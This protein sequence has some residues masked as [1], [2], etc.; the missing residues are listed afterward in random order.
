M[1]TETKKNGSA[2]NFSPNGS[3]HFDQT[4]VL[5]GQNEIKGRECELL[6]SLNND[7]A[8]ARNNDE[9]LD[10]I[11]QNL[12]NLLGFSHTLIC[13]IN[14]D[15]NTVSAFLLDPEAKAKNHPVYQ[16][17]KKGKYPI[18]DGVMDKS[19][20][21]PLP[22]IFDLEI[23]KIDQELPLYLQINYEMGIRQ[24]VVTRFSKREEVFGFWMV[25][26]DEKKDFDRS[27]LKLVNCLA[28][29]ISVAVS[30][31]IANEEI[32]SRESEKSGILA[33]SNAIASERDSRVLANVLKQQLKKLFNIEDY[34]I[35]ALSDD[36]T[37]L[38]PVLFDQLADFNKYPDFLKSLTFQGGAIRELVYDILTSKVPVIF[39]FS[40]WFFSDGVPANF[41]ST[42][43]AAGKRMIGTPLR[44]G[45][46]NIAV[47]IF[48]K[49]DVSELKAQDHLFKSI[50]SQIAIT[51][52]NLIANEKLTGQL[53]EI[54]SYKQQ[55][56]QERTYLKEEIE[57]G[58]NYSEIVGNSSEMQKIFRLVEQVAHSD[59]TV[60]L[61]GETGTGKELIARAIHNA[62]PRKSQL[63][64]K[65][66][67]AALPSNLI[68]SELFGHERGSFT[69]ATERRIGKFE[70][71]NNGTLFLDEV[72]EM[73]LDLQAKL[74]R[75]LQEREIERV[76]G[77]TTIKV[78]VR[79][80]AATNRDL[81]KEMDEGRFRSDLF[82]RL[83]IFPI[84]LPPL[85]QRK[86]DIPLLADFFIQ[87]FSKKAG[88]KIN[89]LS[90]HALQELISYHWPGNIR[91]LEHLIERS[92]LLT[93]GDTI[94]Q[95]YLPAQKQNLAEASTSDVFVVKSLDE[96]ER[97]HIL[98]MLKHCKGRISGS[99]GAA[100]LLGVPPS[101]LNSKTKKLG[102][103]REHLA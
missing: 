15:R 50:C 89:S 39:N 83:N 67:C 88:K 93:P 95:I 63:M 76:G 90:N 16:T 87:R 80:I 26:F 85:R 84:C 25:F 27:K 2:L 24:V 31:I 29:Q 66:N 35:Y 19:H 99:G 79:I 43:I 30:N 53:G 7:I 11:T 37:A 23:L 46:E 58:Q 75:A 65:V 13:T 59:S 60:L 94:K 36:K 12:K 56:E 102:I 32:A 86:E 21:T 40:E 52:A 61:L 96:N 44:L 5:S 97:D 8:A 51:V 1:Q 34:A 82:Y 10:V 6:L 3:Y 74:L 62:S 18:C 28:S 42:K 72:G 103:R 41:N 14:E 17:A 71:A 100:E 55:L 4:H 38:Y 81:E 98:G 64:V 9:L 33:F 70:L 22:V 78:N 69:G 91:E 49:D 92:I 73:P 101:T 68:E 45:H 77:R 48:K 54:S 20:Q 47:L 57:T